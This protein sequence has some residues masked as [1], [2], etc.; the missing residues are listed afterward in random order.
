MKNYTP[1]VVVSIMSLTVLLAACNQ[2]SKV[3]E[4]NKAS[5]VKSNDEMFIKGNLDYADV[6]ISPDYV[7]QNYGKGPTYIKTFVK[8]RR[9]AFP[10]LEI[11]LEPVIADGNMVAWLRTQ[12]GTHKNNYWGHAPTGKKI[13][14]K[15]MVFTRYTD[16]GKIVE[17]WAL[18]NALEMLQAANDIDGVY[19]YLPPGKGQ[20]VNKNGRF[21]YLFGSSDGKSMISQAGTYIISGDTVK[22]TITYCTDP[23]QVGTV[24]LWKV[25]SWSGD[26]VS[27]NIMNDKGEITG[28]GKALRVSK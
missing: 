23:G 5:V 15:E 3:S 17:E 12:S 26:T 10:D 6:V 19:E 8:E 13:T 20:S 25:K 18:S 14:W 27:L 22:N 1:G 4:R 7:V 16:D 9:E 2:G 28:G 21:V 24:Y 11:K